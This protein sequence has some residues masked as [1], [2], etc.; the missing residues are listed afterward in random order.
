MSTEIF[1]FSD[2]GNS[3]H[4]A[5]RIAA[6]TGAKLTP[7]SSAIG[8]DRIDNVAD[9]VGFV[10]P[11]YFV[12]QGGIPL[13]V[14]RFIRKFAGLDSKYVFA[15]YTCG[16]SSISLR[17]HLKRLVREAGGELAA[18]FEVHMPQNAFVK[19]YENERRVLQT[20]ERKIDKAARY[21][22]AG[23][24]GRIE[25]SGL[26]INLIFR[27]LMPLFVKA[28]EESYRRMS[29]TEGGLTFEEIT[30]LFSRS[31]VADENCNGCGTCAKVCPAGNI[32]IESKLPV[33][34][35]RCENCLACLN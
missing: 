26:A 30:P 25:T 6:V 31:F 32:V 14:K 10:S 17:K 27:T 2:T 16:G 3:L 34:Q 5:K 8:S 23:K 12:D 29:K 33:W 9:A 28:G 1:W 15:V 35:V 19:P 20:S 13:I 21:I 24:R 22:A 4:A 7:M 11:T 18:G